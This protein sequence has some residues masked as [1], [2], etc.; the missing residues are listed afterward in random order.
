L[1]NRETLVGQQIGNYYLETFIDSG[2]YGSVYQARHRIFADD[3]PVALKLMHAYLDADEDQALFFQEARLLRKLKH[4]A[5]L[6]VIDVGFDQGR[7]YLVTEYAV[8]GSLR[9]QLRQRMGQPMPLTEALHILLSIGQALSHAHQQ[10]V[11]HRDLKPENILFNERGE[12]LLADFGIAVASASARTYRA[13]QGGTPAYMAPEQF[14]GLVSPKSD[15]YALGCLGYELLTGRRPF[16][17]GQSGLETL[18]FQHAHVTPMPLSQLNPAIPEAVEQAILRALSKERSARYTDV[19]AFLRDV[20]EPFFS[21][22]S[23][24]AQVKLSAK[25]PSQEDYTTGIRAGAHRLK[26][27]LLYDDGRYQEA[28]LFFKRAVALHPADVHAYDRLGNTYFALERYQEALEAYDHALEL[29]HTNAIYEVD[30]AK[31]L[32]A[33]KRD[34]QAL[35]AC[36]RAQQLDPLNAAAYGV[37]GNIYLEMGLDE[38]AL[39]C[40]HQASERDPKN[41]RYFHYRGDALRW[42]GRDEE[43]LAAYDQ[44]LL[45]KPASREA[46][47]TLFKAKANAYFNLERYAAALHFYSRVLELDAADVDTWYLKGQTLYQLQRFEEALE[48]FDRVLM[49]KAN[50]ASV[51]TQRGY[52][53]YQLQRFEEALTSLNNSLAIESDN[54]SIYNAQGNILYSLGRYNEALAMYEKAISL[55]PDNKNYQENR[56][57]ILEKLPTISRKAAPPEVMEQY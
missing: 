23:Q 48:T 54:P 56:T 27:E 20:C 12:A 35:E 36:A 1:N 21:E 52:T 46:C 6:P 31:A 51:H 18:W 33:L 2:S 40:Y 17:T 26:G 9:E 44:A 37:Q 15:Q 57:N 50:I 39:R 13:G 8:G 7:P 25:N 34:D 19:A 43:A 11:F 42:L 47:A 28:L 14:E 16:D 41:P 55:A 49:L 45:L 29:D 4:P 24:H 10:N 32:M 3:P 53:L 5:I 38:G 22:S 30:R